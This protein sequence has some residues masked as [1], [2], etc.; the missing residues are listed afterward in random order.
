MIGLTKLQI[1]QLSIY[2]YID[3]YIIVEICIN[4]CKF[5]FQFKKRK[6]SC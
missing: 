5:L 3:I 1:K 6:N 4:M 2:I